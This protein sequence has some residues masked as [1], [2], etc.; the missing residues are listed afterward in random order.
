[1]RMVGTL[2]DISDRKRDELRLRT[3]QAE[4]EATLNALP[5]LL[6]EFDE[7]GH[8]ISAHSHS[9]MGE[10]ISTAY[11]IGKT[12]A[13]V[14]PHEAAQ[15]CIEA[16]AEAS[17][18]GSSR[19]REYSL[20]L[21]VGKRWYELSVVRKPT[22]PDEDGRFIAIARDITEAKD[23][24]EA[25]RHLA[26]HDSL[27]GLPNRRLLTERL[28]RALAASSR[29][30]QYGA[31]MFLDLDQFKQLNDTHGHEVGDLL[32][33]EV[34]NRLQLSVR[35]IDTVARL[36]GDEFVVLIQDLSIHAADARTHARIVG[37]K[38]LAS[39]NAPFVLGNQQHSTTP[40][41]GLTLFNGDAV[42]HQELLKRADTAMYQAKAQGRNQMQFYE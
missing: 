14:L 41:I 1:M 2:M 38:I 36:G 23:S 26:F 31:L 6:F 22:A 9:E 16:L 10:E 19:G 18:T 20:Q 42:G 33:M 21:P 37:Q 35:A 4:L 39:L 29:H 8:Y 17:R 5:D 13:E 34:A 15:V 7:A 11:L 40:S 30:T 12:I 32:L 3:T 24:A 27:T 25:I 28:Q